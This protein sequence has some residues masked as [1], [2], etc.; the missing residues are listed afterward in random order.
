[1]ANN[2]HFI[3]FEFYVENPNI[4]HIFLFGRIY[5][6]AIPN[7]YYMAFPI[8]FIQYVN[9]YAIN[10]CTRFIN[11]ISVSYF[12]LEWRGTIFIIFS[13][14]YLFLPTLQCSAIHSSSRVL[15]HGILHMQN[16]YVEHSKL[17][18]DAIFIF[19]L[20]MLFPQL[21]PPSIVPLVVSFRFI[22]FLFIL[23]SS[24]SFN[25]WIDI[26]NDAANIRD[27]H[28]LLQALTL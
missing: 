22:S 26:W 13:F 10:T 21:S 2:K 5:P 8:L 9:T 18:I 19:D 11:M 7:H 27:N 17:K 14:F 28:S 4:F 1:M 15:F 25:W 16:W 24:S 6:F 12:S 20:G 23:H 3:S